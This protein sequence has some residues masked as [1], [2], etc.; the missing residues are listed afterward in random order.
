MSSCFLLSP[1]K[2]NLTLQVLRRREDGYHDIYTVFQKIDIFDEVEVIRGRRDFTLIFDSE[3]PIP[4]EENLVY[5]A[6]KAFKDAFRIKEEVAIKVKKIIPIGAGLGGGSSNAATVLKALCYLYGIPPDKDEIFSIAKSLGAD[7]P[8]FLSPF[9]TAIG[10]GI[11]EVLSPIPTFTSW[12]ILVCPKLKVS[13]KWA[14]ESL[15]LTK[16]KNPVYYVADIPPWE[17]RELANDFKELIFSTYEELKDYENQL[18]SCGSLKVCL[19]GSGPTIF[20]IFGEK[21]PFLAYEALKKFLKNVRIFLAKT[22]E[23]N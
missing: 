21:P 12:Y 5:K 13:T 11:G 9:V 2:I 8:F 7:V 15:G 19:S 3:E 23:E 4:V 17:Q 14:Y 20:G 18:R 6:W 10:E 1:A 16:F 22:L